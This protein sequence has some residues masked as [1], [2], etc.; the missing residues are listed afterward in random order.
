MDTSAETESI[1][2]IHA[3]FHLFISKVVIDAIN[4]FQPD[5][6]QILQHQYFISIVQ[7]LQYFKDM[8]LTHCHYTADQ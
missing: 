8:L 6:L 3:L 7:D 2:S 4:V 1:F 5:C